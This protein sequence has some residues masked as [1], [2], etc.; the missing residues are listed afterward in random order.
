MNVV[1]HILETLE[2]FRLRASIYPSHVFIGEEQ[3]QRFLKL[4]LGQDDNRI[5]KGVII[6]R[7]DENS[8]LGAGLRNETIHF[9]DQGRTLL[10]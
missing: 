6:M 5:P 7:I 10:Q 8:F 4:G 1:D 3:F 2:D 9:R